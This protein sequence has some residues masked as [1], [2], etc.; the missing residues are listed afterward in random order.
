[1]PKG[2]KG[3]IDLA[4]VYLYLCVAFPFDEHL[5]KAILIGSGNVKGADEAIF[6]ILNAPGSF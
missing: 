3:N 6:Y 4:I 2:L 5:F 1:M